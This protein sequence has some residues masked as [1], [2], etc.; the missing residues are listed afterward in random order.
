MKHLFQEQQD[1]GTETVLKAIWSIVKT[2]SK[3]LFLTVEWKPLHR[4]KEGQH[5]KKGRCFVWVKKYF[6]NYCIRSKSASKTWGS[7]PSEGGFQRWEMVTWNLSD[8][9]ENWKEFGRAPLCRNLQSQLNLPW[10]FCYSASKI[11]CKDML[12]KQKYFS[13]HVYHCDLITDA[14]NG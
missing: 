14:N 11:N 12:S 3:L 8:S 4:C 9:G 7:K 13:N 5:C 10:C 6:V 2:K 1:W